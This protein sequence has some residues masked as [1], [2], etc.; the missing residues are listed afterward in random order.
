M[1]IFRRFSTL[2]T[3][4]WP[5]LINWRNA[6]L[7]IGAIVCVYAFWI[8][9][10]VQIVPDLGLRSVFSTAIR[11][12]SR[13]HVEGEKPVSGDRVT[14]VGDKV[15][16]G[17]AELLQAP[18][19]LQN[20][21]IDPLPPW[22]EKRRVNDEDIIVAKVWFR[23]D[24]E[25][26]TKDFYAWCQLGNLPA[27]ELV[28]SVLWFLLKM[29]LVGVGALVLLK[30]PNDKAATPFF[31]LCVVT[32]GAYMGGYHWVHIATQPALLLIFMVCAVLL[33]VVSLHFYLVFPR[34]KTFLLKHPRWSMAAMYG[35]PLAML[36]AL[37]TLY[38][39]L[40]WHVQNG[41]AAEEPYS[42][43]RLVIF[44]SLVVS[45]LWYLA[46]VLALLHSFKT[47]ADQTERNQVKWIFFG[48]AL[49][50]VPI[51]YSLFLALLNPDAFSAGAATW[52][53][54][55]A[56][57]FLTIAFAISITRYRL[58]EL[59]K[60]ITSGAGYFFI[61]FL[62]GLAYYA[63]V[64]IGWFVFNA[65]PNFS[66]ALIVTSTAL[67]VMVALDLARS[68]LKKALDRRFSR[69]KSQLDRTLQRLG[70]AVEQLVDPLAV[71]Q[72]LLQAAA[73]VLGTPRGAVFLRQG[74]PP[75]YRLAGSLGTAPG[76]DELALG[77]PVIEAV[78]QG[79]ILLAR[80][81]PAAYPTPAQRQLQLLGGEIAQPLTHEN[82]LLALLVL[83]PKDTP[84]RSEDIDLL[85]AFAQITVLALDSAEG[86][87]TIEQLNGELQG[88]VEKIAEQQRRILAL[89]S[90]LRRQTVPDV[91]QTI[92][93]GDPGKAEDAH[94]DHPPDGIH[95][96]SPAVRL[97]LNQVRKVAGTDAV[98]LIRGES[99]VGKELLA[100]AVH[101][102][103]PRAAKNYVKV[104]C[105][106][107]APN[108]LESELFGHVKGAFT[109]A[110]K[111]KVGRFELANGGTLFLDEIGDIT[112]DDPDQAP[113]R[114]AGDD[115]RAGRLQRADS[116]WTSGSL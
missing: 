68:R 76:L 33:P 24:R 87:R 30:R 14:Q 39:R 63:I 116:R 51:G 32:L 67:V 101:E 35:V 111:D 40:R 96:D 94:G 88:K 91:E 82:R 56:S 113:P 55:A 98:V 21:V 89:Q 43:L 57:V 29:M 86:H 70:Q 45:A 41:L 37:V 28:P 25:G 72:R 13:L 99:G 100:R 18:S 66:E 90:Q 31:L 85:A 114:P 12:E 80:P 109:G 52:P 115:L 77:C 108:L 6:L 16:H 20:Q 75:L 60:I 19:Y 103:S 10:Y 78:Q 47:A 92:P 11:G 4:W 27:E 5:N 65:S 95:G 58:M 34:K 93:L 26:T 53:M 38:G 71:A 69:E 79:A 8:L 102:A 22:L 64:F 49:A 74:D 23:G 54:F 48:A 112:L 97:L 107:L 3:G 50:L 36:V 104:H 106:A 44:A 42:T 84:Y 17:W 1:A 9:I 62:A 61:S 2:F 7:F 105:A 81:K 83:G 46:S 73:D 110:H 59:D 15:I